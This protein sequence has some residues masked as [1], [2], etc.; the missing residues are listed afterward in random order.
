MGIL[1]R[2]SNTYKTSH[3]NQQTLLS[4][5]SLDKDKNPLELKMKFVVA[6]MMMTFMAYCSM[7]APDINDAQD[8]EELH[9]ETVDLEDRAGSVNCDDCGRVRG[10][11]Y[12]CASVGC[13]KC[14]RDAKLNGYQKLGKG[15][16]RGWMRCDACGQTMDKRLF[17]KNR[18]C[19][20]KCSKFGKAA[21]C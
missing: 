21:Q 13:Q 4:L 20:K 15:P 14:I 18:F 8:G 17:C 3:L 12:L 19:S 6:L 1:N 11:K 7:A 2:V 9:L 5:R 16:C 10:K